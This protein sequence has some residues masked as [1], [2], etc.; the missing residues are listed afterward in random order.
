MYS[1][2]TS[3]T[4]VLSQPIK[5]YYR[6]HCLI[7]YLEK[8]DVLIYS[9]CFTPVL[10]FL[11]LSI[12]GLHFLVFILEKVT[13]SVFMNNIQLQI[14]LLPLHVGSSTQIM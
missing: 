8:H 9:F 7:K 3:M 12:V 6:S 5:L 2:V 4:R 11:L 10:W 1:A 14:T 13:L